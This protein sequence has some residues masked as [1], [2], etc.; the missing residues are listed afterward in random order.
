MARRSA[1]GKIAKAWGAGVKEIP[2]NTTWLLS[3]A[4]TPLEATK[5]VAGNVTQSASSSLA[6]MARQAGASVMDVLPV[7]DSIELR[8]QRA[9]AAADEA[10][11]AEE[12]AVRDA[13]E[14]KTRSDEACQ[15]AERCR[16]YVRDVERQQA[17]EV[18][19]KVDETRREADAQVER[20]RAAAQADA[21]DVVQ[22]AKTEADDRVARAREEA[23]AAQSKAKQTM[24][25]A[26][27]SLAEA[28]RLADEA[29]QATKAAAEEAHRQAAQLAADAE[30]EARTADER[31][32]EAEQVRSRAAS[33]PTGSAG[34]RNGRRRSSERL[35][36]MSRA[37]LLELAS[38]DDIKGR[39]AMTKTELVTA[40][41]RSSRASR[42]R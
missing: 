18:K 42:R 21:D 30:H 31:V 10:Q 37:D 2:R 34:S 32:A 24:A 4:L 39:S 7:G 28:R 33:S 20:A 5:D 38:A 17:K 41:Q 36:A 3:K 14:A 16:A 26:T 13:E 23:E 11:K 15:V 8:L 1:A 6:D 19:E 9:R 25:D 40:L 27:A 12:Q 35:E 22:R 29:K